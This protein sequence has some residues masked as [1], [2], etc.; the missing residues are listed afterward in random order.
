MQFATIRYTHP[1][2]WFQ[3][4]GKAFGDHDDVLPVAQHSMELLSD[5]TVLTLYELEGD[6]DAVREILSGSRVTNEHRVTK[7]RDCVAA[8]IHYTP[9]EVV[10]R[11]LQNTA[12][13][14]L[15]VD[16]PIKMHDDGSVEATIIGPRESIS[17]AHEQTP[18]VVKTQVERVGEYTPDEQNYFER[19]SDRQ[20]EV[21]QIAYELG[22]YEEP[23][24][25]T[26][27]DIAAH[28]DCSKANVG[29]ILRRIESK[30]VKEML[31]PSAR[32][33]KSATR[34]E[35]LR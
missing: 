6:A 14:G 30:L 2:G 27:E 24:Q 33:E 19:L 35:S 7:L 20:Q 11:L 8:Y 32:L 29:Q 16:T 28:L 3:S 4:I 21:V 18:D 26:H 17:K 10:E 12:E 34:F 31:Q 5:G 13:H 9:T 23:R 22:Y 15:V 1:D 25:A